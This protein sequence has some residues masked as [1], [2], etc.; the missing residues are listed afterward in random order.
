M[1]HSLLR[2]QKNRGMSKRGYKSEEPASRSRSVRWVKQ[3]RNCC[4][5]ARRDRVAPFHNCISLKLW[6]LDQTWIPA[7]LVNFL[8]RFKSLVRQALQQLFITHPRDYF[9]CIEIMDKPAFNE[10][11]RQSLGCLPLDT[12]VPL[13]VYTP[14]CEPM[15]C[16]QTFWT[17]LWVWWRWW[18][19]WGWGV[20]CALLL[21]WYSMTD[22]RYL[23]AIFNLPETLPQPDKAFWAGCMLTHMG[24]FV[25]DYKGKC[26]E[27]NKNLISL[28]GLLPIGQQLGCM[29]NSSWLSC[30]VVKQKEDVVDNLPCTSYMQARQSFV[31]Y[32]IHESRPGISPGRYSHSVFPRWILSF[33]KL[34]ALSLL[35]LSN[36]DGKPERS[37]L[38]KTSKFIDSTHL[39]HA[40][41][42]V[43]QVAS[44]RALS[45]SDKRLMIWASTSTGKSDKFTIILGYW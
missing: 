12:G 21:T 7:Q 34:K 44:S 10:S 32:C 15:S 30:L 43:L 6:N 20:H 2:V 36:H 18:W 19:W 11:R 38:D 13:K 39:R 17:W 23:L 40:S 42:N 35:N 41:W 16:S 37:L 25:T 31:T 22:L 45:V 28:A 27:E 3:W 8:G 9:E 14:E 33:L 5:T 26:L 4:L 29:I 1:H 24:L